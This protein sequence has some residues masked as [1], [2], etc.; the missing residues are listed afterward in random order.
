[1]KLELI[2][3]LLLISSVAFAHLEGEAKI[4]GDY[5]IEL[6]TLPEMLETGKNSDIVIIIENA[7]TGE[8]MGRVGLWARLSLDDIAI[9][10]S[11]NL[12]TDSSG[13]AILN[14]NFNKPGNYKLDVSLSDAVTGF[15]LHVSGS[16]PVPLYIA[17]TAVIFFIVGLA[18]G[19][20]FFMKRK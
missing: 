14:Y 20:I 8:R 11:P 7:T 10:S 18:A 6:A 15:D 9:I 1:M 12:V 16:E 17:A 4:I 3:S 13:I 19:M 5:R 2:V